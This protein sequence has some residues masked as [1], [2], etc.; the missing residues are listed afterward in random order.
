MRCAPVPMG[1]ATNGRSVR[2]D[3]PASTGARGRPVVIPRPRVAQRLARRGLHGLPDA[4]SGPAFATL[5]GLV[6]YAA[7]DP[8]DLR[9]L[10]M[11]SQDVY[12]PASTSILHRLMAALK[13][14]F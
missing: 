13:S 9:D 3:L 12:R 5:A 8:V 10:P 1:A 14:S 2:M 6:L 11:M 4:H 7:S